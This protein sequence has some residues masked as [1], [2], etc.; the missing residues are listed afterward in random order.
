MRVKFGSALLA[1]SLLLGLASGAFA[2][3][4]F[5]TSLSGTVVDSSGGVIPGANVKIKNT[6]TGEEFDTVTGAE[7]AFAVPSL[8]GGTYSVTVS[9]MGFR[10]AT[11][12]SVV[13]NAAVPANVKV[14]MQVGA[15][16]ENVTVTGD[17]ALVVQTQSPSIATN[18]TGA[19]IVSL[20]LTSR[21]ALDSL[22]SL[23]GFNTSGTARNS[24]VA[25]L[26]KGA[27]NI[28]LDGMNIQDNYL[29]TSD[30]YFAR[31]SPLLD[32]VEDVT[33]TMAG[34]TAD[35]TGQGG[36]QI[37][38]VT[39]SGTNQWTGTAYEY[40]RH[41]ALNANTWFNNRDLPPDPATGKAPKPQLRSYT[42][43]FAQG[44]P[45]KQNKAFFFFNYEEQR[46]P[47]TVT[48]QRV[49]LAP[50]AGAG[51][52]TYNVTGGGTRTVN[53]LQLAAANGQLSTLD[54]TVASALGKIQAAMGSTGS[55]ASLSNPLVQQYT[56]Q[57]PTKNFNPSPTFRLD[58]EINDKHRLTGSMNY[59]HINSTPDTTNNAQY[60]FPGLGATGSQ[61]STRW[62]TSESLRSVLT[63]N[64][65]NEFRVG[66][67]GGAT[68]FSP[69]LEA[70]MFDVTGGYRLRFDTACCGTGFQLTN[71]AS[72]VAQTGST[73]GAGSSTNSSREASTKVIEDTATWLKGKHSVQF[74]GS[75]VQADV[76]LQNQTIVPSITF[77][78]QA[79]EAASAMFN[80][81]NFPGA[82][83]QDITNATNLYAM[84]TGRVT[85]IASEARITEAGDSYVPLGS[86]RAAGRMREFDFYAADQWR[87]TNSLTV[88][89]GLRYVLEN[90]FY[91]VNNSYTTAPVTSMCGI[92][93]LGSVAGCSLFAPGSLTGV[94]PTFVQYP[95]G[96]YAFNP[97]RNNFAPSAGVAWQ[98]PGSS[99]GI[100]RL[101][102]GSEDGDSVLRGGGA[103]AYQRPGMSDFTGVF[104]A[105]QGIFATLNRD[106]ATGNLGTLPVLL[107]NPSQLTPP[108]TPA[109]AYPQ[110]PNNITNTINSFDSNL[111][112]PY[113]QSYTFGWQRKLGRDTAFEVRYVGSRHRMDWETVNLNEISITD[114]GFASEFRKAQANLQANIAA[115][116][117]NTFAYTGAP[118]T[119]PLPIFLAYYAGLPASQAGD[120]SKYTSTQFSN[121]TNLNF[122]AAMNP[123][124][125][126]FA[127][128]NSTSGLIGNATFRASGVAAGLPANFFLANPDVLGGS[129]L[130]TNSGGTNAKAVQFEFRKRLSNGLAYNTSYTW[131]DATILQRYGF[132]KEL[133][134]LEQVGQVG[135]VQHAF[136]ANWNY[137]LPFGRDQRYGSSANG[138]LENLIGGWSIDGVARIQTGEMMDFGNVRLVGMSVDEFRKAIDLRV[139]PN[140]QLF[141]LPDDIIQNTV[142]AFQVS[143]TSANGYSALGAPTGRYLAPA[144]GPDCL[145]TEPS[146]GDC[147]IRSLVVNGPPLFRFDIGASKRFRIHN[148]V[149]FEFRAELL[150]AFNKPYFNPASTAGTPL[151]MSTTFTAPGGP[152]LTAT[153]TTNA[154]AGSSADSFRLTGLLGDNTS[155]QGQLIWRVRW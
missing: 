53:L 40:F 134:E 151:G 139:A 39:K 34:N 149:T 112:I 6:G 122:L 89:A 62:T 123:N 102:F 58:Y 67:T 5:F 51:I 148:N 74:G 79:T 132:T 23:A 103:M 7:G 94:K 12:N 66:G 35:A 92:S 69:E 129:N 135:N 64:L 71:I 13:L 31:L 80:T 142:K 19:Q 18:L 59:R 95:Q 124:P 114:N 113:A 147:G 28:T 72:G 73:A 146:A 120:T 115:G 133:A 49:A 43:G 98:I 150:N 4:S 42:Q 29:K 10:T 25:G 86:S 78:I 65:V 130:T 93:G 125:F 107:R 55:I 144:N 111:Q 101:I 22:T 105:N 44:G 154:S 81:T 50:T 108:A 41:D 8:P 14:T 24:T 155:R 21:N 91:P 33:V 16:E 60:S 2:Q 82:A 127:S 52:F 106:A 88:S 131:S 15:L 85:Q 90:P 116:K 1:V 61:Q 100:S 47:A 27:I 26:P 11:L 110:G 48:V 118:G 126:G 68:L 20:P 30:G 36:V 32:S 152:T 141:I 143:A 3:G 46:S 145:E 57:T 87:A 138:L 119:S 96:Q 77:G 84:L 97:D 54:P 83:A 99:S 137:D 45:I 153:P 37:K 76:W 121:T 104:G 75:L 109:V 63:Q 56:F 140:G 38:F 70:S 117:G 128:T 17:S 136:K 9:L